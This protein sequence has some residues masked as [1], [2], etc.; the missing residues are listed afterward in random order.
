MTLHTAEK[1]VVITEKFISKNVCDII[2]AC[3]ATG[4]TVVAAGGKGSRDVRATTER[5]SVIDDF[6]NVKIEVIVNDKAMA[7]EIMERVVNEYFDDYPGIT[8]LEFVEVLRPA[9]FHKT[10]L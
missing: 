10:E 4:Y 3:G 5:A 1:L 7:E 6:S 9:K 2:E 8:Y